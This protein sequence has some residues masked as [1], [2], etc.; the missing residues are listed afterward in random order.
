MKKSATAERKRSRDESTTKETANSSIDVTSSD[1]VLAPMTASAARLMWLEAASAESLNAVETF[2]KSQM[3]VL[4]AKR[5]S[6]TRLTPE[7]IDVRNRLIM[8]LMQSGRSEQCVVG[9][10]QLG[11]KVRLASCV[12]NYTLPLPRQPSVLSSVQAPC[13]AADGAVPTKA[14][15]ALQAAL[16]PLTAAYWTAHDYSV[17]PPSPY[18]SF[19]LPTTP[20][21][22]AGTDESCGPLGAL[23]ASVYQ[24]GCRRFGDERMKKVHYAELWGHNRPHASGHQLHYDSDDEGR[25][26]IRNPIVSSVLFLLGDVGGPTLVTTQRLADK[27]LCEHGWLCYPKE[28]RTLVF[29]GS[30]LHGVIPGRGVSPCVGQRRVT[31]MVALWETI[32]VRNGDG[33]GSARP[34][35]STTPKAQWVRD[36]T[37]YPKGVKASSPIHVTTLDVATPEELPQVWERVDGSPVPH[38]D[39]ICRYDEVYQ[40]F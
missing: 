31:V 21:L 10:T 3:S 8:L 2:Y 23:I 28:G 40:G 6:G 37:T 13:I 39:P 12:L 27:Q 33:P 34:F 17:E 1:E 20:S 19:V 14:F 11:C 5:G 32:Q 24:L 9:L 15:A 7:E 26:G 16:G 29:D 38:G 25:D 35:P 18:F 4:K 30:V 22:L 36:L